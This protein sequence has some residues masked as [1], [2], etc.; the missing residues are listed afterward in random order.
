M[1]NDWKDLSRHFTPSNILNWLSV[2]SLLG[3]TLA[4]PINAIADQLPNAASVIHQKNINRLEPSGLAIVR[5]TGSAL[6]P[7]FPL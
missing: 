5:T 2:L 4:S 6:Q 7:C 3:T 1:Q